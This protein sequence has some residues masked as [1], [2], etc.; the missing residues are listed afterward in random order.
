LGA[1]TRGQGKVIEYPVPHSELAMREFFRDS[2]GRNVVWI[3]AEQQGR[4]LL[5]A[6]KTVR[7]RLPVSKQDPGLF[8]LM[9]IYPVDGVT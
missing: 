8:L 9:F 5:S 3:G 6:G 1:L 7:P 2:Q 4:L